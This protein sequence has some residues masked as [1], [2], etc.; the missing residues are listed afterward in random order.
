MTEPIQKELGVTTIQV[1]PPAAPLPP[2]A[3]IPDVT[4]IADLLERLDGIPADRVRFYPIPG[5][6]TVNDVVAIEARGEG[7]CELVDGVLVEKPMG[8]RESILAVKLAAF[9][10]TFV[11]QQKLG[12]VAGEAGMMQL[13]R[14]LVRMPDVAFIA[15]SKFPGGH[16]TSE[17]AP[18]IA[19]DLAVEILSPSNTKREMARKL[20]E[21][22]D[23]GT[24]LVWYV[25]P[26]PR[27]VAVFT[28]VGDPNVVLSEKETLDGGDV[29]PGFA[30]PLADLFAALDQQA[31][32]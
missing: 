25:D 18:L 6:A 32:S 14:A 22:F 7:L 19:P 13:R 16:V 5:T 11:D 17:P 1:T 26:Q 3:Q 15:W 12:V 31:P 21:Y 30:L 10:V 28:S 27:T 8:I 24:R 20:R 9:L 29:L 4:T 2:P 23:A